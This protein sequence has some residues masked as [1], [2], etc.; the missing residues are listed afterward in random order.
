VIAEGPSDA[1]LLP[2]LFRE[3]VSVGR[4]ASLQL[5]VAGGLASTPPRLLPQLEGEAGH[6]VYLTDSDSEGLN[7]E[8][9]LLDAGVAAELIFT[10]RD[11]E[12]EGLSIEDSSRR[13]CMSRW[14]I[15]WRWSFEDTRVRPTN[16]MRLPR[17]G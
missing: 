8:K 16:S 14:S 9:A 11:G 17:R 15:C 13:V 6:V 5:P 3:A 10:L 2:A 12:E 7:Y 4:T 1:L